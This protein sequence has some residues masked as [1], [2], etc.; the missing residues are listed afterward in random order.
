VAE[1]SDNPGDASSPTGN[2]SLL[3]STDLL[4]GLLFAALGAGALYISWRYP[5]GTAARMGP[6][7]FPHL[8]SS[9]LVLLGGIL[10]LRAWFRP[11]ETI[12]ILD[13]RPLLFVLLGTVAFGLLIERAGLIAASAMVVV[14]SRFAR[15]GFRPVEVLLLAAGLAGGAALLFVYA[16]GLSVR[17][18]P[19]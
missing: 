2:A 18:L 17:L 1:P 3:L 8:V 11:G 9:L 5:A 12:A 6:G 15:P 19:F 10:M 13:L 4:S 14:A 16:L 7:Y